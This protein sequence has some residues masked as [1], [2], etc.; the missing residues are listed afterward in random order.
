[1]KGNLRRISGHA[2]AQMQQI[3]QIATA[4]VTVNFNCFMPVGDDAV[5]EILTCNPDGTS[6]LGYFDGTNVYQ[7]VPY[8]GN[9]ASIKLASGNAVL[10]LNEQ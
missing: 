4:L 3:Q 10:Y 5:L 9:F 2:N 8:Y 6:A 1:M 7:N